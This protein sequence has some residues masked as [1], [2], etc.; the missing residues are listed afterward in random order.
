MKGV[1]SFV[2]ASQTAWK[3]VRQRSDLRCLAKL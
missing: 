1:G 3:G 2:Q